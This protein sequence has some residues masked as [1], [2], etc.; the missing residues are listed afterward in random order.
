LIVVVILGHFGVK[1]C[2]RGHTAQ[3]AEGRVELMRFLKHRLDRACDIVMEPQ[4][5]AMTT[6]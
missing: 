4:H 3:Y 6:T 2:D 5:D 1:Q